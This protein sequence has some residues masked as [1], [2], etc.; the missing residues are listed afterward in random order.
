VTPV[1]AAERNKRDYPDV[2]LHPC[3]FCNSDNLYICPNSQ[4]SD[5]APQ[6]NVVCLKCGAGQNSI[7]K[8]NTRAAYAC[9]GW[10]PMTF[11]NKP[12]LVHPDISLQAQHALLLAMLQRFAELEKNK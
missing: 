5:M 8:W 9:D 7:E 3:P 1:E 11:L 2:K 6:P 12:L 10:I 4:S